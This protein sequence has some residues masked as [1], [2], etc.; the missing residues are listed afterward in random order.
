M[1]VLGLDLGPTSVGW[2]LVEIEENG[3]PDSILG[4]GS[5]I[6]PYS[7]DTTAS[8]FSKGKGESP[9]TERTRCRQ[10]RRNTD[11]F[12]LHREQLKSLLQ[13]IGMIDSDFKIV[14]GSPVEVWKS[15]ADAATAN[16]KLPLEKL[17][18]VLLHINHRRG[19]R[20]AKSDIGDSKQTDYVAKINERYSEIQASGKTVG[21]YFYDK[22]KSS[23]VVN[24]NGKKYYSYRIKEKV[25]PRK[26]YENEVDIILKNQG[27]FYPEILTPEN[28]SAIKQVIFYQRPLKSCKNLVSFCEF[29][30]H[31][32]I[33][34]AGK[35][36]ENGPKVSSRTSPLA[37]VCRIYE[38][39]NNIRL[40]N[41][42]RKNKRN[43]TVIV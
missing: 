1:K 33:N 15:R 27:K 24:P 36:V 31:E 30:R 37:Q 38:A 17:A 39:I 22:L 13:R 23:E 29:E 34:K 5:R 12:Q 41:S 10:M 35:K 21:Q 43:N 40:V 28:Q 7:E 19:Y 9:C 16:I 2:A 6:I 25:C 18:A 8:D 20:H 32:F 14:S 3:T 4:L 26:A 11:R 42:R